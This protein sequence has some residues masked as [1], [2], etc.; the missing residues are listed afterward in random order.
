MSKQ[1]LSDT[2]QEKSVYLSI[3]QYDILFLS[4]IDIWHHNIVFLTVVLIPLFAN[5]K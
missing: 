5:S 4:N 2:S 3:P 1:K